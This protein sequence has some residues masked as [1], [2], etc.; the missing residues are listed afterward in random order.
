[1]ASLIW[2]GESKNT[3]SPYETGIL[4]LQ[5]AGVNVADALRGSVLDAAVREPNE[6]FPKVWEE[7]FSM[8]GNVQR[9]ILPGGLE[10]AIISSKLEIHDPKPS[11][12]DDSDAL[13]I[14]RSEEFGLLLQVMG[15]EPQA[16]GDYVAHTSVH[17]HEGGEETFMQLYGES[18]LVRMKVNGSLHVVK[19][20]T[21]SV[22]HLEAGG[23]NTSTV[24]VHVAH[25]LVAGRIPS[26][27]LLHSSHPN[28]AMEDHNYL[29]K[30]K[31]IVDRAKLEA[32]IEASYQ[33]LA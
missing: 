17:D 9:K 18:H 32:A 28:F 5:K 11:G 24:N 30:F 29:S 20:E 27:T 3:Q 13:Y 10:I 21:M 22:E 14:G 26:I 23:N 19:P 33:P 12:S 31:R 6:E 2:A 7:Y 4:P 1:M 25:P 15:T 8:L 16:T